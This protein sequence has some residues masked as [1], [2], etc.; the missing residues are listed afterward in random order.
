[1]HGIVKALLIK[2]L[3]ED[4]FVIGYQFKKRLNA[5]NIEV[6]NGSIFL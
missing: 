6:S 5:L 1:M 4:G 3:L 2:D